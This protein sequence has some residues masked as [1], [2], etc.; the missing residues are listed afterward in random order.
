MDKK[1]E[2]RLRME[3]KKVALKNAEHHILYDHSPDYNERLK[4][5]FVKQEEL[6]NAIMDYHT[7]NGNDDNLRE[8]WKVFYHFQTVIGD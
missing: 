2:L 8:A 6:R 5:G 1:D 7:I 4:D 3:M